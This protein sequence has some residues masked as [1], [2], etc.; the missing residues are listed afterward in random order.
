MSQMSGV[1]VVACGDLPGGLVRRSLSSPSG[2]RLVLRPCGTSSCGTA[3]AGPVPISGQLREDLWGRGAALV[4]VTGSSR[5]SERNLVT[6]TS[7]RQSG[8]STASTER[9]REREGNGGLAI[10]VGFPFLMSFA[11]GRHDSG[12]CFF[13]SRRHPLDSQVKLSFSLW[14]TPLGCWNM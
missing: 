6:A 12:M 3:L 11:A 14:G 7:R 13:S 5:D 9:D 1:G 4:R 8:A 10:K 2:P